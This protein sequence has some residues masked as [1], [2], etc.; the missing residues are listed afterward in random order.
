MRKQGGPGAWTAEGEQSPF[1]PFQE[2]HQFDAIQKEIEEDRRRTEVDWG[3]AICN[4]LRITGHN[5]RASLPQ[6]AA[7]APRVDTSPD[8]HPCERQEPSPADSDHEPESPAKSVIRIYRH[9]DD[10]GA[11]GH[12]LEMD[13][14]PRVQ[15]GNIYCAFK[16]QPQ[17]VLIVKRINSPNVTKVA[18]ELAMFLSEELGLQVIVEPTASDEFVSAGAM[19]VKTWHEEEGP[20]EELGGHIDFVVALGGDGTML[21]ASHLMTNVVPPVV[22]F[23]MGSLG[24]LTQFEVSEMKV[25]LRRMVHFGFSICLRCR[26]KVMLVDSHDVIKHESNAINDCVVDRGPGSFLTNLD[27]FYNE[28]FFTTVAADGL[29]IATPTGSTAYS[30]SAGGSMVHP[31]VPCMLFTPICPHSLSFRPLVLPDSGV[32]RIKVPDDSRAAAWVAVDGRSRMEIQKGES[33]IITMSAFPYPMVLRDDV[34]RDHWIES[35]KKGLNW[36]QRIRQQAFPIDGPAS[37]TTHTPT[38]SLGPEHKNLHIQ[39]GGRGEAG[40][41]HRSNPSHSPRSSPPQSPTQAADAAIGSGGPN[42]ESTAPLVDGSPKQLRPCIDRKHSRS[43]TTTTL[44][45]THHSVFFPCTSVK[46]RGMSEETIPPRSLSAI[47]GIKPPPCDAW[48]H[49][50]RPSDEGSTGAAVLNGSVRG[51]GEHKAAGGDDQS[52]LVPPEL[53]AVQSAPCTPNIAFTDSPVISALQRSDIKPDAQP[54][55]DKMP[56]LNLDASLCQF[57]PPGPLPSVREVSASKECPSNG[58]SDKGGSEGSTAT[59]GA[60]DACLSPPQSVEEGTPMASPMDK[61]TVDRSM[62]PPYG[63]SPSKGSPLSSGEGRAAR[64]GSIEERNEESLSHLTNIEVARSPPKHRG[65]IAGLTLPSAVSQGAGTTTTT[66]PSKGATAP[67]G[68]H[69]GGQRVSLSSSAGANSAPPT[70]AAAIHHV[71]SISYVHSAAGS[72]HRASSEAR[73]PHSEER[74]APG[75]G[76]NRSTSVFVMPQPETQTMI[77]LMPRA[78]VSGTPSHLLRNVDVC[79][80][81]KGDG[82]KTDNTAAEQQQTDSSS[83]GAE[84]VD[85]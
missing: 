60:T 15:T 77:Q 75:P 85:K 78:L 72:S 40:R 65:S 58:R 83:N 80:R 20:P 12:Y 34:Q 35:L 5:H 42:A 41:P 1:L 62:R 4:Q 48:H 50:E 47:D 16:Q 76:D 30:M 2:L 64:F 52:R 17:R 18:V 33:V 70:A 44:P 22:G 8:G 57:A 9:T 71:R 10:G 43:R 54:S 82:G 84:K 45:Q 59:G 56:P 49:T 14:L 66:Q 73:S 61:K 68:P 79:I 19:M 81:K 3:D 67:A 39:K 27:V 13:H 55:G 37:A 7:R 31:Q 36:N 21:W 53:T 51:G 28:E 46:G 74:S 6:P 69:T 26:L 63:K 38:P 23:S 32:L 11:D 24:Y 29:I 25:V